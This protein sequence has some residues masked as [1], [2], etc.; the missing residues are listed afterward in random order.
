MENLKDLKPEVARKLVAFIDA[1]RDL[2][3][4]EDCLQ[5][6][7]ALGVASAQLTEVLGALAG[8]GLTRS[9]GK[10]NK[11]RNFDPCSSCTSKKI[12]CKNLSGEDS[13]RLCEQCKAVGKLSCEDV[14]SAAESLLPQE[15]TP[16]SPASNECISEPPPMPFDNGIFDFENYRFTGPAPT[17]GMEYGEIPVGPQSSAQTQAS[18]AYTGVQGGMASSSAM[19]FEPASYVQG[20]SAYHAMKAGTQLNNAHGSA[21][22]QPTP[23]A[24]GYRGPLE[25]LQDGAVNPNTFSEAMCNFESGTS[26]DMIYMSFLNGHS[27]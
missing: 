15:N 27:Q 1:A 8:V 10:I 16:F 12:R 24:S 17:Q 4:D 13:P 23:F 9:A 2:V 5:A 14:E 25:N 26:E 6:F 11:R 21:S 3:G 7:G 18:T 19:A 22:Y 20:P